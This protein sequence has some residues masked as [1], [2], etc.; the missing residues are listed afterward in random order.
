M[1]HSLF[2]IKHFLKLPY[3]LNYKCC[4]QAV[5]LNTFIQTFVIIR[6]KMKQSHFYS[7]KKAILQK[8]SASSLLLRFDFLR[9]VFWNLNS[10][11]IP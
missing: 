4:K 6:N 5:A 2:R 9:V 7:G 1:F 3:K 11:Q 8:H 10:L